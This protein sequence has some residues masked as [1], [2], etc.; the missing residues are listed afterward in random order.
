MG[1]YPDIDMARTI[2]QERLKHLDC[3]ERARNAEAAL[4]QANDELATW[5]KHGI[6]VPHWMDLPK[7]AN[8]LLSIDD[9]PWF[10]ALAR[11]MAKS[12]RFH[13]RPDIADHGSGHIDLG[14]DGGRP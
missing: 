13:N 2:E 10:K 9:S 5:R 8:T 12:K 7:I 6:K 4:V 1:S 11:A 3:E 14:A